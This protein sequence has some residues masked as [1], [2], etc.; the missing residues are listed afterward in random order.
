MREGAAIAAPG[1]FARGRPRWNGLGQET[2]A[3]HSKAFS[4]QLSAFSATCTC[5]AH[6]P[7]KAERCGGYKCQISALMADPV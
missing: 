5:S 7:R 3:Q 6:L 2:F 1:C 4:D